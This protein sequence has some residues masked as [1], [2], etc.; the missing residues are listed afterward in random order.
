MERKSIVLQSRLLLVLLGLILGYLGRFIL[1]APASETKNE[2]DF[3][4]LPTESAPGIKDQPIE[5]KSDRNRSGAN[6]EVGGLVEPINLTP[7]LFNAAGEPLAAG[8]DVADYEEFVHD[9]NAMFHAHGERLCASGCAVSRHP[10]ARLTTARF[11]QLLRE[12]ASG[13][14]DATNHAL[15]ELLYFGRQ[16][17]QL[18]QQHGLEDLD[19][20]R[21]GLLISELRITHALVSIRVV[22]EQGNL[23]S[24]LDSTRVPFDRRHV[25]DMQTNQLPT[26]ITSGTVKRVGQKHLWTRL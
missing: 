22:D 16:T 7:T 14:L 12:F 8:V 24:W 6:T 17:R 21:S 4:P 2:L 1:G 9:A 13:P 10:T 18:I 5:I 3:G 25:F 26:L 15:E 23:R 20:Q 19:W 11:R